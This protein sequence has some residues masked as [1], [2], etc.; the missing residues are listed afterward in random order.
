M[1]TALQELHTKAAEAEPLLESALAALRDAA[2]AVHSLALIAGDL[3]REAADC[4][5]EP[6]S[7]AL[8]AHLEGR[9]LQRVRF[10][11]SRAQQ[12]GDKLRELTA[13]ARSLRQDCADLLPLLPEQAEVP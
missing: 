3:Q 1:S 11:L 12:A 6:L 5:F 13:G 7:P 4:E 8:A 10:T 2:L 9:L